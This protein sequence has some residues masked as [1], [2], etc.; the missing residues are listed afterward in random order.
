MSPFEHNEH[1]L[2]GS[3][4]STRE[5]RDLLIGPA[6]IYP[7]GRNNHFGLRKGIL[8]LPRL[9]NMESLNFRV[10]PKRLVHQTLGVAALSRL[11]NDRRFLGMDC[12]FAQASGITNEAERSS[13]NEPR[14]SLVCTLR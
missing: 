5:L 4:L 7:A 12:S 3:H 2:A 14:I 11:V 6:E 9:R 1:L 10:A 8:V 13:T